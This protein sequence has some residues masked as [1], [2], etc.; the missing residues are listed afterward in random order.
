MGK[1]L[2]LRGGNSGM[3]YEKKFNLITCYNTKGEIEFIMRFPTEFE[4]T[5]VIEDMMSD[6]EIVTT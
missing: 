5:Q 1:S 6:N 4:A 2:K 3:T